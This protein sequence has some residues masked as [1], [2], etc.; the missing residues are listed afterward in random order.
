MVE[1]KAQTRSNGNWKLPPPDRTRTH[2]SPLEARNE[3][4]HRP[5]APVAFDCVK[6]VVIRG[7]S[8]RLISE[9][10]TQHVNHGDV[11]VLAANTLCG[12]EPEGWITTT[13][14]YLDRDY[15]IDQVFWQHAALFK[16][17]LDA[18][19]FLDANYAEPAQVVR[20]GETRAAQLIP[21]LDELAILSIEGLSA[22]HFYRAQA[23]VSAVLDVVVPHLAITPQ[24]VIST[25][26][27]SVVPSTPRHRVFR[28]LRDEARRA[29]EL[30]AGELDRR[31]L[32]SELAHSVHLSSSQLRRVFTEAFG[33]TPI[34]YLT[35]L[36]I[37][38]MAHL[39][40]ATDSPISLIAALVGWGDADFAARQFRRNLGVSPTEYRRISRETPLPPD[41][42]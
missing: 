3:T 11:V 36:R 6:F 7:G 14:L 32:V 1:I 31:W 15:V 42:E 39:L 4:H 13:T 16:S 40:K 37:E 24:R 25:R 5:V 33:K 18:S 23:L 10:G 21:W 9:F 27:S 19:E 28:P 26:R 29:A 34:T 38:R 2:F 22:E 20:L 12:A 35:M 41:P 30:L 17:R 8:A